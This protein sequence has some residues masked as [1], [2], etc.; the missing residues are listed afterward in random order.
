MRVLGRSRAVGAGRELPAH[1]FHKFSV[2]AA[3]E[4]PAH[5]P[6]ACPFYECSP[7]SR[8]FAHFIHD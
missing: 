7:I 6:I 4:L 8:L 3:R 1:P 2:G 5:P